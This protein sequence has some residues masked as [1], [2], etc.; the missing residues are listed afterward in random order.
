MYQTLEVNKRLFIICREK[1][2]SV[3][4]VNKKKCGNHT[5]KNLIT[6]EKNGMI[7]FFLGRLFNFLAFASKRYLI[8]LS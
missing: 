4:S 6:S 8:S 1:S 5:R 7:D 3:P 2:V